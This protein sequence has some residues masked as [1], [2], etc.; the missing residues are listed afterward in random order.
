MNDIR[1]KAY[2]RWLAT[3]ELQGRLNEFLK[4]RYRHAPPL[5]RTPEMNREVVERRIILKVILDR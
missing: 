5:T 4:F 3:K 2:K 1:E